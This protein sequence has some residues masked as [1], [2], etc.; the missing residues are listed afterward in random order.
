MIVLDWLLSHQQRID[1][2]EISSLDEWKKK[3]WESVSGWK[4]PIDRAMAGGFLSDR[5]GYAFA[6]G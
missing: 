5:A 6:A 4:E 2:K 3:Y 1:T